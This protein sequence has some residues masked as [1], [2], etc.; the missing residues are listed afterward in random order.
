[1]NEWEQAN[2]AAAVVWLEEKRPEPVLTMPFLQELHRRMFDKTWT[3]AGVF[4]WTGKNIGV[5]PS[6]IREDLNNLLNDTDYGIEHRTYSTDEVAARFHH[7][8]VSIHPFPNGN[9]R[10]ARLMTQ[11]LQ[12]QLGVRR[13]SWGRGSLVKDG[14]TRTAYLRALQAADGGVYE[15]L[16]AFVRS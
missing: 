6:S 12:D 1:M 3:W 5:L 14:E 11:A 15:Q 7:R 8:L 16:M 4:R 13:F 10:H 2:I 9:G